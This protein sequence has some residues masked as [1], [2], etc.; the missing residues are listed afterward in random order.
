MFFQYFLLQLIIADINDRKMS[1]ILFVLANLAG[2]G[3]EKTFID[4]MQHTN[5]C[6]YEIELCLVVG[7]GIYLDSI[8]ADV[9]VTVLFKKPSL[10]Y[11][12]SLGLS[13]YFSLNFFPK[14]LIRHKVGKRYDRI[15]S[16]TEGIPLLFHSYIKN[17]ATRNIAWIHTDLR[18]YHYTRKYFRS[19]KHEAICYNSMHHLVFVSQDAQRNFNE[20][21]KLG[22]SQSVIYNPIDKVE[23]RKKAH[24]FQV[25]KRRFTICTL[26]RLVA[27]KGYDCFLRVANELVREGYMVDFWIV[28]EGVLENEL[29]QMSIEF[30]LEEHVCFW[31][32][33]SN[34]YPFIEVADIFLSTSKVEGYPLV[35]CEALCLSKPIVATRIPGSMEILGESQYGLLADCDDHKLCQALRMLLDSAEELAGYKQRAEEGAKKFDIETKV[36]EIYS[37]IG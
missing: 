33:Q 27:V 31:G 37:T 6:V 34:P 17:R 26:G 20:Q 24:A 22:V 11:K 9:K 18:H 36:V 16:Y 13:K 5:F 12:L 19:D 10:L 7:E 30:G 29:K 21:F 1:K 32:F 14:W 3:A 4:L 2:G 15:V 23:I 28:G 25:E 8:P 35:I